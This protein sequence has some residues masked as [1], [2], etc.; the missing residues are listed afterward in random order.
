MSLP[1]SNFTSM[2]EEPCLEVERIS[3]ASLAAETAPSMGRD[4]SVSMSSGLAPV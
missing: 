4:I 3:S 2:I 1:Q